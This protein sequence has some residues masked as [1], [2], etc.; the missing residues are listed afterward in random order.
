[1]SWATS[2]PWQS[3]AWCGG[4]G[5]D[6]VQAAASAAESRAALLMANE[7]T[8]LRRALGH[9]LALGRVCREDLS[10]RRAVGPECALVAPFPRIPLTRSGDVPVWADLL[11]DSTQVRAELGG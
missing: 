7:E 5:C 10:Q 1:M 6:V 11:G 4:L 9:Q 2:T 8:A 3:A